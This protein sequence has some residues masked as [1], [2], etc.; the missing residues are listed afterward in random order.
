MKYWKKPM[1]RQNEIILSELF[2]SQLSFFSFL[3]V[4]ALILTDLCNYRP[5]IAGLILFFSS[6]LSK[7]L[8]ILC[9]K[10]I[11]NYSL[12]K[13]ISISN[14]VIMVSF[15]LLFLTKNI[16]FVSLIFIIIFTFNG[17]HNLSINTLIALKNKKFRAFAYLN[18]IASISAGIGPFIATQLFTQK[19]IGILYIFFISG[20]VLAFILS[21]KIN[22]TE[23]LEN[24][25]SIVIVFLKSI[26]YRNILIS[27]IT[28]ASWSICIQLLIG[29]PLAFY[30]LS[31]NYNVTGFVFI[32]NSLTVLFFSFFLKKIEKLTQD[33]NYINLNIGFCL[34]IFSFLILTLG[35][36]IL[37]LITI[38]IVLI[39]ISEIMLI[40][41]ITALVVDTSISQKKIAVNLAINSIAVG[42][43]EGFGSF[44]G[45]LFFANNNKEIG[46][47]I[48]MFLCIIGLTISQILK[49]YDNRRIKR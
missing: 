40:S 44:Y 25:N 22:N 27:L 37:L 31:L 10:L 35:K 41:T 47:F 12:V 13:I 18:I 30:Q 26:N 17:I 16:F 21:K 3:G 7:I 4:S 28:I 20:S 9:A 8:R 6:I 34:S 29:F 38:S 49:R 1:K 45:A 14:I 33:N 11:A 36:D 15:F 46:Y 2:M 32:I 19:M 5:A 23:Q 48:S 24:K 42:I 39:S 43:G